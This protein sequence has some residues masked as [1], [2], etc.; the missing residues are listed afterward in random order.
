MPRGVLHRLQP[1][2]I[3]RAF[4]ARAERRR[5]RAA[6][7]AAKLFDHRWYLSQYPDVRAAG[8]DPLTHYLISGGFEGRDPNPLFDSDWYLAQN[9]EVAAAGINPLTHYL[10]QG[11]AMGRPPNRL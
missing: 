1:A 9:P 8:I 2:R 3:G 5:E 7:V 10:H 6:I 4:A 11:A